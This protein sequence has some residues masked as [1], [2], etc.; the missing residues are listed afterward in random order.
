MVS[1]CGNG[2][3]MK[4]SI[5]VLAH[6]SNV[7]SGN[8]GLFKIV[9]MLKIT[10]KWD[11]VESAFLKLAKPGLFETIDKVVNEGAKR[12]VIFPLILFSGNH[13]KNDIPEEIDKHKERYPG[14]EFVYANNLGPDERIAQIA[15]DRINEALRLNCDDDGLNESGKPTDSYIANPDSIFKESFTTIDQLLDIIGTENIPEINLPVIKRIIHTTG[16]PEYGR[17]FIFFP[18]SV[19]A[20]IA[21]ICD[22]KSIVTDVNMVKAGINKKLTRRFGGKVVCKIAN[23]FVAAQAKKE[24]KTRAITAIDA[25]IQELEGGIAAIGNAPSAL[26]HLMDLIDKGKVLPA[27]I[28]GTPVGFIGAAESKE[29]LSLTKLPHIT[30]IGRKGG[31]AVAVTI[32]NAILG[33]AKEG[34]VDVKAGQK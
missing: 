30:N 9:D 20:G 14:V 10:N 21:A 11:S 5:I 32:V 31:S 2:G 34:A 22:G 29:A 25:S 18:G 12:V 16:D 7:N 15:T 13:A 27:L 23:R 3:K 1:Y 26:F 33:L 17:N 6:G 24:G 19:E 4:T 8:D 28:I